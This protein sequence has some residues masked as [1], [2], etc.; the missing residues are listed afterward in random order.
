MNEMDLLQVF[1]RE[2]AISYRDELDPTQNVWYTSGAF[3]TDPRLQAFLRAGLQGEI[4]LP[5]I[6]DLD[7]NIEPNY[8]N[9]IFT[10]I[11]EPE[12]IRGGKSK[13]RIAYMNKGFRQSDM[14]T[15]L[16]GVEPNRLIVARLAKHWE[17]IMERR[18]IA[19][20]YGLYNAVKDVS[21]KADYIVEAGSTGFDVNAFIDAE[22]LLPTVE[23]GKGV[24]VVSP[25]VHTAMRKQNLIEH[26]TTSDNL[27]PVQFYNGRVVIVAQ[28][29]PKTKSNFTRVGK[30]SAAKNLTIICDNGAFAADVVAGSNDMS[31]E[32]T[33]ATGNGGGHTTLWT[34]K[35]ALIHPQGFSF[36]ATDEQ[37]TG[38]TE[39]EALSAS[40]TDLANGAYWK[41][42]G[43][44]NIRFL[45]T[46]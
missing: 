13:A 32:R 9:T 25:Y 15:Q 14:Q 1:D 31:T 22:A 8:S 18:A 44:S 43:Q 5:Y 23:Q 39:V 16:S 41:L 34:R 46:A 27:P 19:T 6:G 12:T 26:V 10:D 3:V 45:V 7:A 35:N 17:G 2:L 40:L 20:T 30:G 38:G 21:T 36:T 24:I 29:D 11:A 42:A 33:E 4:T 28:T 37:L